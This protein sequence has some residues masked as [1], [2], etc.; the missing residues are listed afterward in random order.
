MTITPLILRDWIGRYWQAF[1]RSSWILIHHVQSG[2]QGWI[3]IK[4][5]STDG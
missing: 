5:E 3:Y 4:S 1:N 2:K